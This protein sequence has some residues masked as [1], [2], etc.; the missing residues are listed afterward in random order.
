VLTEGVH[1][2]KFD[3]DPRGQGGCCGF[4]QGPGDAVQVFQEGDAEVVSDHSAVKA[5]R[6][7]QQ[8]SEQGSVGGGGD[9]VQVGVGMHHGAYARLPD[10]HLEGRKQDVCQLAGANGDGGKVAAC[11]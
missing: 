10:G 6:V 4:A 2:G 8:V 1:G 11:L 7:A 9:T 3:V 5:P